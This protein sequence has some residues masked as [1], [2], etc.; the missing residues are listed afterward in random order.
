MQR[1]RAAR[2]RRRHIP[3]L[4]ERQ[5]RRYIQLDAGVRQPVNEVERGLAAGVGNGNLHIHVRAPGGDFAGLALHIRKFVGEHL[6]RDRPIRDGAQD[7][8]R[9]GLVVDDASLA[10]QRRIGGEA[11]DQRISIPLQHGCLIRAIRE[12]LHAQLFLRFQRF[13]PLSRDSGR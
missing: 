4:V 1:R 12:D 8:P 6:E 5:Q 7:V 3:H 2:Q 9:K 11:L 10:H 13:T